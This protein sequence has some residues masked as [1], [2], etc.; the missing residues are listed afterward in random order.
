MRTMRHLPE[1]N[2]TQTGGALVM[3]AIATAVMATLSFSVLALSMAGAREQRTSKEQM[4]ARFVCEAGL[5]EAVYELAVSS[6]ATSVVVT[7]PDGQGEQP[8]DVGSELNP[9]AFGGGSFWVDAVPLGNMQTR[10]VATGEVDRAGESIELTVR[11][12]VHTKYVWGAFGDVDLD[13]SSNA[14]V[15][16]YDATLGTYASQA[17]NNDGTN[18]YAGVNGDV[19]SNQDIQ[20]SQNAKVWG[21]ATPGPTGTTEQVGDNTIVFGSTLPMIESIALPPI[22]VP[23]ILASGPVSYTGDTNLI[24]SGDHHFESILV[25]NNSHVQVVGPARIVVGDFRLNAG[26]TF[27]VDASAGP[28]ELYVLNDF[29]LNSNTTLGA[30]DLLPKNLEVLLLSDNII[31]PGVTVDLDTVDFN[32][33]A[34]LFGTIYAP[35][36][37]IDVNSNFEQFGSMVAKKIRLRSNA[38]VHYDESLATSKKDE[39]STW[40]IV[41]WR[42]LPYQP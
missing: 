4:S 41:C 20:L 24:A 6:A 30:T 14:R 36:A 8:G 35:D 29:L 37:F 26:S 42:L 9:Q 7:Q 5:S 10:L 12:V 39:D 3:V 11:E 40:E 15:D 22:E 34:K 16:S 31:D 2:A 23:A 25:D 19:G 21:D 18:T 32:S 28:V 38:T 33:N 27:M 1:T 17:V 13:M